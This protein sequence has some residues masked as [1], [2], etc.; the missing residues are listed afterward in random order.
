MGDAFAISIQSASGIRFEVDG[1]GVQLSYIC[2]P[3]AGDCP[4]GRWRGNP[5]LAATPIVLSQAKD[6]H[7]RSVLVAP[8]VHYGAELALGERML[9]TTRYANGAAWQRAL[10]QPRSS[11]R[12]FSAYRQALNLAPATAVTAG[13]Q[14]A[15]EDSATPVEH[16]AIDNW[17]EVMLE[18]QSDFVGWVHDSV[19]WQIGALPSSKLT[20]DENTIRTALEQATADVNAIGRPR[21]PAAPGSATRRP[22]RPSTRRS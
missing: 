4:G 9:G 20:A 22:R 10:A 21:A 12:R 19:S 6:S 16:Q 13:F 11:A 3:S 17:R 5:L 14:E 1:L 7:L 18:A 15:S 8:I 2:H